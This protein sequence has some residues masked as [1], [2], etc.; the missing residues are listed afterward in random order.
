LSLRR[1]HRKEY[2][3]A[4]FKGCWEGASQKWLLVDMHVLPQWTNEHLLP[5]QIDDKRGEPE[6]TPH[7]IALVKWVTELCQAGLWACHYAKEFTLQRIRPLGR[8]EKLAYRCSRLANP[9]RE[10]AESKI[11]N[12][13]IADV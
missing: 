3:D 13:L 1:H 10:P 6:I 4:A 8:R 2:L 5:P 12:Y 7:Q 11:L 9:T